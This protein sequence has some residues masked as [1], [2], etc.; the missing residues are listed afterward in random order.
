MHQELSQDYKCRQ[1]L[2]KKLEST[3]DTQRKDII[4]LRED[5]NRLRDQYD[6]ARDRLRDSGDAYGSLKSAIEEREFTILDLRMTK[7]IAS[8]RMRK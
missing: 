7:S 5:V 4:A 2:L 6:E 3:M 8:W 1:S